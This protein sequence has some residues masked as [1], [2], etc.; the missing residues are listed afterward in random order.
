MKNHIDVHIGAS[1][2][3]DRKGAWVVLTVGLETQLMS[4]EM[5]TSLGEALL[6][7][8]RNLPSIVHALESPV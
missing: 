1:F 2:L 4:A 8:A 6:S 3:H 5:A 7:A